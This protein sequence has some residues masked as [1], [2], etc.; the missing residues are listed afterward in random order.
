MLLGGGGGWRCWWGLGGGVAFLKKTAVW[1]AWALGRVG[2]PPGVT[3]SLLCP[4]GR[5]QVR[6]APAGGGSRR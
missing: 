6:A 5:W 4:G 2:E 3:V 1:L